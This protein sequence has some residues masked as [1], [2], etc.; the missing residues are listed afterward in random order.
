MDAASYFDAMASSYERQFSDTS[1]WAIAH[2]TG[3]RLLTEVCAEPPRRVGDIGCGSGK[4][5]RMF[6]RQ[7]IRTVFSDVAPEMVEEALRLAKQEGAELVSGHVGSATSLRG[8][9]DAEFDLTLCMGDPL[10]Y[11]GD[12]RAG[13]RE[14]VRVTKPGA[15]IYVSVDSRLG[16]LRIFKE[17]RGSELP[18]I[19]EFLAT[20]DTIGWEGLPLHAF[21]E[22][23]LAALFREAGAEAVGI[24]ELPTVSS[25]FL[26][27]ERFQRQ[28]EEAHVRDRLD[29]IEMDA[30]KRGAGAV[31]PHHLY[32]LFRRRL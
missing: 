25:Y 4:W 2:R 27:E 18:A 8:I 5:G 23:E 17:K 19:E 30:V 22:D 13:V 3:L 29:R 28:L 10:S 15:L 14:L 7:G 1:V 21:Y 11:C 32:G 24:W 16:Y 20:G 9:E 26:F 6:S 12:Y 31:G